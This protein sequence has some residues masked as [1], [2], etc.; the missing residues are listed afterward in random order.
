MLIGHARGA[1]ARPQ[2]VKRGAS[3]G[4]APGYSSKDI[5]RNVGTAGPTGL[6]CATSNERV[7]APAFWWSGQ[8]GHHEWCALTLVSAISERQLAHES[9]LTSKFLRTTLD[10]SPLKHFCFTHAQAIRGLGSNRQRTRHHLTPLETPHPTQQTA[11]ARATAQ[12]KTGH[13]SA[14]HMWTEMMKIP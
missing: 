3:T 14:A 9:T 10:A 6:G 13:S 11:G 2:S 7:C 12:W 8:C 1:D 5:A 4:L